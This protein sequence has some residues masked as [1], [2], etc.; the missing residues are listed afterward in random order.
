MALDVNFEEMSDEEMRTWVE[1]NPDKINDR[2]GEGWPLLYIA[3]WYH[4]G[5]GLIA[6]LIDTVGCD[7]NSRADCGA[8]PLHHAASADVVSLLLDRRADPTLR[9]SCNMTPL[10]QQALYGEDEVASVARLLQDDRVVASINAQHKEATC[11]DG[12]C[13]GGNTALH[14]VCY[15]RKYLLDPD[16]FK[17]LIS[18]GANPFIRNQYGLR[19]LDMLEGISYPEKNIDIA[20]S[21]LERA[22]A[23][24]PLTF[25]LAKARLM[26]DANHA[27]AKVKEDADKKSR[28]R[29]QKM[30]LVLAKTPIY[31]K[32]RVEEGNLLPSVEITG[33]NQQQQQQ[34][35]KNE[36]EEKQVAVLQYVLRDASLY[37]E[38]GGMSEDVFVDFMDMLA[39]EW[40]PL[41]MK[42]HYMLFL[43]SCLASEVKKEEE[44]E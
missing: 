2:N 34:Q 28:T 35:Q 22:M 37:A 40:D 27:I 31:L 39:P 32:E 1:N 14:F 42:G 12:A 19:P 24:L 30:R 11:D 13:W 7:V 38:A 15:T 43:K 21:L 36:Q 41:R 23:E 16:L 6:W 33:P 5:P 4:R 18:H 20:I 25:S 10:M 29:G 26:N 17:V 44:G 9:D 3:T 8:T